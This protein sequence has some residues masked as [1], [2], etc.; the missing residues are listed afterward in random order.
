MR[1]L[2]KLLSM[3]VSVRFTFSLVVNE[4]LYLEQIDVKTAFL[5]YR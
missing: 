1:C 3:Y 5:K 4:D 2:L